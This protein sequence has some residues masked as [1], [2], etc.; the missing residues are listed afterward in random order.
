MELCE[1]QLEKQL[2]N[3]NV[4]LDGEKA[5]QNQKAF[6]ESEKLKAEK[7]LKWCSFAT[8]LIYSET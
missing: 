2:E 1:F 8:R 3:N 7:D 5:I 4:F 6:N